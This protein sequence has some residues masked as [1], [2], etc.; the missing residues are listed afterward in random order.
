MSKHADPKTAE[1]TGTAIVKIEDITA[2]NAPLIFGHNSL[3]R[4][5][6]LARAEVV[7]E[8]PDLTTD[9]G[10]KRIAS[11]AATVARSKTAV[12]AAGR[13]YLKKLK[14]MP[15]GIEAELRQFEADMNALRDEVRKP[16]N[17]YETAEVA[18]KDAIE[19]AVQCILDLAAIPD[20]ASA[21]EIE[22]SLIDLKSMEI[23][24]ATYQERLE[25]A[26]VKQKH[27]IDTL[28]AALAKRQQYEAEQAELVES[29]RKIAAMEEEARIK[30]AAD[31][32]VEDERQR[33]AQEQQAQR[34]ADARSLHLAEE[35]TREAESRAQQAERDR[36]AAEERAETERQHA[37]QRAE[38]ARL[39][40]QRRQQEEQAEQQRQAQEREANRAHCGAINKA[41][42]DALLAVNMSADG[43]P[44]SFLSAAEAKAIITAIIR[45]QIPAVSIA[46]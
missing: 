31:K 1:A 42:L 43:Q 2:D 40:E 33:V 7:G 37:E 4:F 21:S 28:T 6:E 36:I 27:C 32:A 12:D 34:D 17:D 29:R 18:R 45:G 26:Q 3:S 22:C 35:R 15:K 5:V 14:E 23:D 13:A 30:A 39:D 16:L 11:L 38:Q 24:A 46:Y 8:V 19:D 44:E 25:E 9:K 41:A 10:R 20:D